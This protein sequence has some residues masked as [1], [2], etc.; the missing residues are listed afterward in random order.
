M[1]VLLVRLCYRMSKA[2]SGGLPA[3]PSSA[4]NMHTCC[5]LELPLRGKRTY[6]VSP[7]S[8]PSFVSDRKLA[9]TWQGAG[10]QDGEQP[11]TSAHQGRGP[12]H[13]SEL[14]QAAGAVTPIG[15][16]APFLLW[17]V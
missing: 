5:E 6:A 12:P 16:K 11:P 17:I 4:P 7:L 15:L 2:P 14:R 10:S 8:S 13:G 9:H 1:V 3:T